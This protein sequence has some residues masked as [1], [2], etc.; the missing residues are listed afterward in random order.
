MRR[1]L[2]VSLAIA[3]ASTLWISLHDGEATVEP[4]KAGKHTSDSVGGDTEVRR[5]GK[6]SEPSA[7]V[8]QDKGDLTQ[9]P[10][11]I[12][13]WKQREPIGLKS[14]QEMQAWAAS[15][16]PPPPPQPV[17]QRTEPPP[18]PQA[19]RF[20]HPWVGRF[21]DLAVVAGPQS[22]WVLA[23]GQVID[24]VWRVDS[25]QERRMQLTYLPLNQ[26]QTVVM[27]NP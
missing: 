13:A 7:V 16:P 14:S 3:L 9:L 23:P 15:L 22:T 1:S 25:I 27:Q 11:T 12:V 21:N 18:P 26:A 19:P 5:R 20:S 6:S 2:Q 8:R 10:V 24:G 17:A 4:A